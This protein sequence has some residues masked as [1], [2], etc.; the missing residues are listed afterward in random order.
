MDAKYID[1]LESAREDELRRAMRLLRRGE[2]PVRVLHELSRRLTSKLL[3]A[4]TKALQDAV[5]D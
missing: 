3:H 4:P 2:D 5:L 1:A